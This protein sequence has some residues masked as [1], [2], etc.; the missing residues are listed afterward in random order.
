MSLIVTTL[1]ICL[2][3]TSVWTQSSV[4]YTGRTCEGS[5]LRLSCQ[6][7]S[8]IDIVSASYGRNAGSEICPHSYIRVTSGCHASSSLSIVRNT[9]HGQQSC[10][11]RASN[12]VFG[13]PCFRTYKYLEVKYRCQQTPTEI[14]CEGSTMSLSC[15]GNSEIHVVSASYGRNAGP[16][17]CPHSSIQV[18]SGCHSY[19]SLSRV[20][21]ACEGQNSCSI[22][23]SN[24]IFG[25]PCVFTYKYLEVSYECRT[26]S[27]ACEG[28]T[29][30][31][32]CP[33]NTRLNIIT[34]NYGRN[35]GRDVCPHRH[36]RVTSGCNASSS[37][38]KVRAACQGRQSCS[39]RAS[40]SVFGDPCF[41]TYKY[42]EATYVCS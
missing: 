33:S 3:P 28:S 27:R 30:S 6:A 1:L 24:Y 23:A 20:R 36:I 7:N 18:T 41:R 4:I 39:I 37:L 40:N 15:Q 34:A 17:I 13:D 25:D 11:V 29:L 5:T 2:L 9:C 8:H 22:S 35:A 32:T 38:G 26:T 19:F 42:L 31:L 14:T 21:S 12:S 10:S 16:E